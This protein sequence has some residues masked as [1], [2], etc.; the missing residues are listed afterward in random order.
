MESIE[1]EGEMSAWEACTEA[2]TRCQEEMGVHI[3]PTP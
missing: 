3:G 1:V 2:T